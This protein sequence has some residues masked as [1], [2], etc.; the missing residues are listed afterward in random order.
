MER[1]SQGIAV[2]AHI[3]PAAARAASSYVTPAI[4]ASQYHTLLAL[5]E[6]GTLSGAA[7]VSARF[8]TCS[9][10]ASSLAGWADV[11]S[12]SCIT[13]AFASGSNDKIGQLELQV[14]QYGSTLERYIRVLVSAS[15]SSWLGACQVLGTPRYSPATDVDTSD[16]V[17]TVVY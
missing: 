10:S 9:G 5:L 8:Q 12:A 17:Q 4:D 15:T 1:L 6:V 14:H 3:T 11:N 16:V 2:A 7:T 13:S